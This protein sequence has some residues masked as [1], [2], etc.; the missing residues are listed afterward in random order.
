MTLFALATVLAVI[1]ITLVVGWSITLFRW[2]KKGY[3]GSELRRRQGRVRRVAAIVVFLLF[4]IATVSWRLLASGRVG[5][6]RGIYLLPFAAIVCLVGVIAVRGLW[7][8]TSPYQGLRWLRSVSNRVSLQAGIIVSVSLVT[9]IDM[10]AVVNDQLF[11]FC[12][13]VFMFLTS[14]VALGS[15]VLEQQ[16]PDTEDMLDFGPKEEKK[17]SKPEG[18]T[19]KNSDRGALL[20]SL[21][22]IFITGLFFFLLRLLLIPSVRLYLRQLWSKAILNNVVNFSI[23]LF[24]FVLELLFLLWLLVPGFLSTS[25]E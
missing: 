4:A 6:G 13:V 14:M 3:G 5:P 8:L 19:K 1:L 7:F 16:L 25:K 23:A 2:Q 15:F 21:A 10:T 11:F 22:G 12:F 9:A 24:F 17:Q 20:I 18:K